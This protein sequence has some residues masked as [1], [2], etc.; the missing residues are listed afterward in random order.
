MLYGGSIMPGHY[1]GA[2]SHDPGGVRGRRRARRRARSTD[3]ELTEIEDVASPGAGAC[4]GQFTANTMAM[5]FEVLGISPA[6]LSMVPAIDGQ[7]GRGRASRPD[8]LVVD[9]LA[10]GLRPSD[11]ITRESLE[12]AIAADRLQRRL[13][14]RRAAPAGDRQ[15]DGRRA[16]DR[17][18]RPDQ[19]AHAAAVRPEAGR[20]VRRARP[21]RG[22]RRAAGAEAPPARPACC[23]SD[24]VDG[25]RPDGRRA[26][27]TRRARPTGQ[28]VV[29][30]LDDPLK[31]TGGLAI[32]RGNARARGLRGQARR[33]RA[34]PA[35]RPGAR[36]RVRGG[37]DGGGHGE[38][39]QGRRRGRDPQRGPGRRPGHARDA[40]RHRG[41]RRRGA[42]RG[43]WR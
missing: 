42:R 36:V 19:R 4:G 25:H 8:E 31:P 28:R 41:A 27:P 2:A 16:V 18:L 12:N 17:R 9:V 26:S 14:Q 37:R 15:G 23:T 20:P 35:H 5:A 38:P 33:A 40:R 43:R 13:D 10:R 7:Q 39:D 29:R 24:A 21:V 22:R 30:P 11:I 32:L 6:G 34:A 3:E 1:H